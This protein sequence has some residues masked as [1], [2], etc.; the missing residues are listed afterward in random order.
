MRSV[1]ILF[2]VAAFAISGRPLLANVKTAN[3]Y[4][5]AA[6]FGK[7]I[8]HSIKVNLSGSRKE[9][10]R[11][12]FKLEDHES[13]SAGVWDKNGTSQLWISCYGGPD[14]AIFFE[15]GVVVPNWNYFDVLDA[16]GVGLVETLEMNSF[17]PEYSMI[18]LRMSQKMVEAIKNA[19]TIQLS[20]GRSDFEPIV[21]SGK[22]SKAVLS[23]VMDGCN[24]N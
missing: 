14:A 3:T 15:A 17:D 12:W 6:T 11:D 22:R 10:S 24:Y 19:H 4:E 9:K 2:I 8:N 13:V 18:N 23:E 21:F 1:W 7:S 16:K 20:F 5:V